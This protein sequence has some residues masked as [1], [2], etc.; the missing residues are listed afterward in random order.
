MTEAKGKLVIGDWQKK[1]KS[2]NILSLA[3]LALAAALFL[4]TVFHVFF[5]GSFWFAVPL[6][7]IFCTALFF[8]DFSWKISIRDVAR[9][10]NAYF[11]EL[12]E[13]SELTLK[14]AESL[15]LL[16]KLQ[17]QKIENILP[18]LPQPK[19]IYRRLKFA[20]IV[21]VTAFCISLLLVKL[22]LKSGNTYF[23]P[24][25]EALGGTGKSA[26]PEVVLP[27]INHFNLKITPPAYTG[28]SSREQIQ[29]DSRRRRN[30]KLG[31]QH[32]QSG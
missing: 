6:F 29:P 8:V 13:S 24:I 4:S 19:E 11:P 26:K 22:P 21:L 23:N 1:W 12:E 30:G 7:L 18:Q 32:Q 27:E 17:K 9:F 14:P 5:S 28:R 16:E 10:L 25:K 15:N 3:L 31:N 20:A 2:S